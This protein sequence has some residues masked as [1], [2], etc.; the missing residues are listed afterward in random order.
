MHT[1]LSRSHHPWPWS[2]LQ[3]GSEGSHDH[4]SWDN[5]LAEEPHKALQGM[6][7]LQV[8]EDTLLLQIHIQSNI[9]INFIINYINARNLNHDKL[10][11]PLLR[12]HFQVTKCS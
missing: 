5:R 2:P 7:W 3:L 11:T 6:Q 12:N 8:V 10:E 1:I 4:V 9:H